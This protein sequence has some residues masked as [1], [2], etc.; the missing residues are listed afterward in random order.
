MPMFHDEA[1]SQLIRQRLMADCR[2]AGVTVEVNCSDGCICLLGHVDSAEQ[3]KTAELLIEG[4]TGV[5]SV[6]NRIM[7]RGEGFTLY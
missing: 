2:T 1:L 3:R 5:R 6:L 4:M 7:V